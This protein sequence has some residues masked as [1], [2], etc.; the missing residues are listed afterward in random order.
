MKNSTRYAVYAVAS[1]FG[2][3]ALIFLNVSESS[4]LYDWGLGICAIF[5]GAACI[6]RSAQLH[7]IEESDSKLQGT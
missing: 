7:R 2:G 5:L 6:Y 4:S 3:A 1:L